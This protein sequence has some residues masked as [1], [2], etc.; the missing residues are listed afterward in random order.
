[1]IQALKN[2][3]LIHV[4]LSHD[5]QC[6]FLFFHCF[7]TEHVY[8]LPCS[9]G[10]TLASGVSWRNAL[11]WWEQTFPITDLLF[12][13]LCSHSLFWR[14]HMLTWD[15]KPSLLRKT[16]LKTEVIVKNKYLDFVSNFGDLRVRSLVSVSWIPT[17]S[18]SSLSSCY[19]FLLMFNSPI[20][21]G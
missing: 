15:S 14:K 12:Y 2:I 18:H 8:L 16:K 13:L 7:S 11:A 19:Y 21:C 1:M 10:M 20:K 3:L 5:W 17:G 4:I 6:F 9:P